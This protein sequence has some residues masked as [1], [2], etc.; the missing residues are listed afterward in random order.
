MISQQPVELPRCR[1]IVPMKDL[2]DSK[3]R[4]QIVLPGLVCRALVLLMLE[5]VVS[6]VV[7]ANVCPCRVVGGDSMVRR[8]ATLAG[9]EW[10]HDPTENLNGAVRLAMKNAYAD[11][12]D[13]ALYFPGDIPLLTPD[14]VFEI[15]YA[16]RTLTRPVGVP[17]ATGGGTNALFIPAGLEMDVELGHRSYAKHRAAAK[18]AGTTIRT[19]NLPS[20]AADVDDLMHY[21]DLKWGLRGFAPLLLDW[22]EWLYRDRWYEP[23]PMPSVGGYVEPHE[24]APDW[25]GDD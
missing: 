5:R 15:L 3:S 14:D 4:L 21:R 2:M 19:L 8:I 11:G 23:P 20:V 17:A 18:R 22:M 16:G 12:M 1:V 9:A 6:A 25:N 10:E 13:A 7:E 24:G